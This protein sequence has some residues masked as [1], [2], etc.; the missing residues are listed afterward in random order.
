[1]R[2]AGTI[3]GAIRIA[4]AAAMIV[5]AT[6]AALSQQP[7]PVKPDT[8]SS[9]LSAEAAS[10]SACEARADRVHVTYPG[11]RECIA[12]YATPGSPKVRTAV[13]FFEG[14]VDPDQLAKTDELARHLD[15][16]NRQAKQLA[17]TTG[18]RIVFVARPGLFGSSGN[19]GHRR[20]LREVQAVSAAIDAIKLRHGISDLVLA[21]QSGGSTL[22]ASLLSEGRRDITCSVLGSGNF[23]VIERLYRGAQK[24]GFNIS[25][26]QFRLT[27][28][29]PSEKT[30]QIPVVATRR[31]FILGDP[32][33]S[34]T[35]FAQQVAFAQGLRARGHHA[36]TVEVRGIGPNRHGVGQA[37][38]L[39]AALCARGQ[40]DA[41]IRR[42]ILPQPQAQ[43]V[44]RPAVPSM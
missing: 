43:A 41:R 7:P 42:A 17:D 19:H 27:H 38:L 32:A 18:V 22:A 15:Q 36:E 26:E 28:Y 16:F 6:T 44:G 3:S 40:E 31:T 37:T 33:D 9:V 30:D 34:I 20:T 12:Y 14:D 39:A 11:G 8:F 1:M 24:R 25:R 35:R 21:G 10:K 4:A 2:Q 13:I 23:E 5:T 29:D